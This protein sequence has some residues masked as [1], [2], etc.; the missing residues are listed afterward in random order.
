MKRTGIAVLLLGLGLGLSVK[1]ASAQSDDKFQRFIRIHN[2]LDVTVYPVIQSPQDAPDKPNAKP[3]NCGTGG[4]LRIIVNN[5]QEGAGIK[6]GETVTVKI[7]KDVPCAIGGFY[8]ASRIYIL[9]ANFDS[10]EKLLNENQK[11]Q[12]Y[13]GWDYTKYNPCV[14]CYVGK[15]SADYG[16]DAPGQLL[17]YTIISQNPATGD[18]FDD[19]NNTSGTPLLDFDVSY[20]DDAYLPV[21]MAIDDTGATQ[22]MGSTLKFDTFKDRLTQ[23]LTDGKWSRYAAYAPVNWADPNDCTA[24]VP[25]DTNKTRFSCLVARIDRM[26]SANILIINAQTGGTSS[27]YRP[28]WDGKS[29]VECNAAL[30]ADPGANLKCSTLRPDGDGLTSGN[31]CPDNQKPPFMQGCCDLEKFLIDNTHRRFIPA[32][33]AFKLSNDT[34]DNAVNQFRKWQGASVTPCR[35]ASEA[36]TFAAVKDP[37][38]FCDSFKKTVDFVWKEFLPQCA[39]RGDAQDRCVTAAII[40]YDLKNSSFDPSICKC[41]SEDE[42]KCPRSCALESQ[43]NASVQALMRGLP[44]VPPGDPATCVPVCPDAKT[45]PT[46]CI[47][48]ITPSASA[49]QYNMDKYL[50]FWADYGNVYNLNPFAR[51]VHNYTNG[52]AAPGAYSF[53]IDDFYGNFGGPGST[54]LI[55]VGDFQSLPNK[56][57]F[58]PY[59]QYSVGFGTGWHHGSVCGRDAFLPAAAPANVGLNAPFSFWKNGSQGSVCEVRAY[60]TA[61]TSKYI[62]F[63]LKEVPV[64]AVDLYTG[65]SHT[66]YGLS[67]VFANRGFPGEVPDEND[68]CKRMSTDTD[69]VAKGFCKANLSAGKL[70][71][72]YVGVSDDACKGKPNVA[73]CGKP[74]VNLNMQALKPV[75]PS[76]PQDLDTQSP[77]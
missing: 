28:A 76:A 22:F 21:A 68:Y 44:W 41:P 37:K 65:E 48:P 10:F 32:S 19:P 4:H 46:S 6:K 63:Q 58:D 33:K 13:P 57:P 25:G 8:D 38:F 15:S 75:P 1:P 2:S 24:G 67:G 71:L 50:H 51:F 17:E 72:D 55:D 12:R 54:L 43:R 61:D 30:T 53:S 59:K 42:A 29:R 23:F 18:K 69:L 39:S 49:R 47:L 31:C 34:L 62:A 3:A 74:L 77:N 26:P 7:P 35:G 16:H 64:T 70:N 60:A 73:D 40:G 45:C 56:E 11:T 52:L 5:G 66:A 27:F 36:I 20:V 9:N 14:G